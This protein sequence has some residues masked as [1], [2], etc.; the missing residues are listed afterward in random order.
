MSSRIRFTE[1]RQVF[2][3]FVTA[4]DDITA[5]PNDDPPLVFL[6]QLS[7]S[8]TPEDAVSFCAYLLPRREAVWWACQC[9]LALRGAAGGD[10]LS[11]LAEAW[12]RD[13]EEERRREALDAALAADPASAT[14]WLALAAGWSG[15]SMAPAETPPVPPPPHLTAKAVRAAILMALARVGARERAQWLRACVEAGIR[16]AEGGDAR[17]R[18]GEAA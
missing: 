1:T 4:M 8:P 12:V 3:A 13:P 15:G 7:V 17:V 6:R 14:T 11:A 10:R 9:V 2:A 16:F 18:F 5:A